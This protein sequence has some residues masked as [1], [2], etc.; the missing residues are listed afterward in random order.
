MPDETAGENNVHFGKYLR[1]GVLASNLS[2]AILRFLL[3]RTYIHTR[4]TVIQLYQPRA[5]YLLVGTTIRSAFHRAEPRR[6]TSAFRAFGKIAPISREERE[7]ERAKV[8]FRGKKGKRT[9]KYARRVR[10]KSQTSRGTKRDS[11]GA[12]SSG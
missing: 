8:R 10:G 2:A 7:R 3:G 1:A 12:R 4:I 5:E 9:E 11:E 6:Y